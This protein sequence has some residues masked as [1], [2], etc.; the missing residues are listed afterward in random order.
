MCE[1]FGVST[2]EPVRLYCSLDEFAKHGGGSHVNRSGW[3]VAYYEDN[4][5]LLIREALP[6]VQSPWIGFLESHGLTSNCTIC[7]VRYASVGAPSIVNTHP[8]RREL[9]GHMHVF[10]HNG[11]LSSIEKK[12]PFESSEFRPVGQ[13]DSEYAFCILLQRLAPLW[14]ASATEAPALADRLNVV[15]QTA[16][17]LRR[18]GAANFLY[19]DGDVL[20]AHADRRRFDVDGEFG[21]PRPPGLCLGYTRDLVKGMEIKWPV[22]ATAGILVAS[23]PLTGEGW[24]PLEEGTVIALREGEEVARVSS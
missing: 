7:H 17:D 4:D 13:T 18:Q 20:F 12:L 21:E 8:F 19:A 24:V 14:Q 5:V 22:T 6:A 3:G 10:A 23:V 16:A 11:T 9:G 15:V 1:L 2:S